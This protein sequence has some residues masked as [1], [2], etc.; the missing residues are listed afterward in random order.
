MRRFAVLAV[1]VGALVAVVPAG[2][3]DDPAAVENAVAMGNR[4]ETPS[5]A[6]LPATPPPPATVPAAKPV[7][8]SRVKAATSIGPHRETVDERAARVSRDAMI[9]HPRPPMQPVYAPGIKEA[10]DSAFNA[11]P[12]QLGT[13]T[14]T[15]TTVRSP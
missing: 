15:P 14:P 1:L 8:T 5:L 4:I 12:I 10:Y 6:T 13:L 9:P 7:A 3:T 2:L 11:P